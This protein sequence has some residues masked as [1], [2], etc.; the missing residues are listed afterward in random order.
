MNKT[1]EERIS[2]LENVLEQM[3][4]PIKN[5]PFRVI[6]KSLAGCDVIPFDADNPQDVKMLI[7]VESAIRCCASEVKLN[8][9]I[10]SRPNEVGNDIEPFV[11]RA[12]ALQGFQVESPKA[13]NGTTKGVGYPDILMF[14][15]S[16]RATYIECKTYHIASENSTMRSFFFVPV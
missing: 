9:I 14:D 4:K 5:I 11:R 15:Q 8:P 16:N 12:L 13:Q 2:E 3:L 7:G 10:R 1:N 6:V